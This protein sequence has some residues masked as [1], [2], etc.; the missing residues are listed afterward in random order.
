MKAS[1]YISN[2]LSKTDREFDAVTI[3]EINK[4]LAGIDVPDA[5]VESLSDIV[6]KKAAMVDRDIAE[7]HK[8][9]LYD[10]LTKSQTNALLAAGYTQDEVSVINNLD[11][12]DRL[13]KIIEINTNKL[14]TQYSASETEQ[15]ALA[16][17]E[18]LAEKER[19]EMYQNQLLKK[20]DDFTTYKTTLENET[21]LNYMID[22]I[23]FRTDGIPKDK[24]AELLKSELNSY[25]KSR[26]AKVVFQNNQA[27]VVDIND[28]TEDY[29]D[30]NNKL[31]DV[32][33]LTIRL[34]QSLNLVDKNVTE[35]KENGSKKIINVG[36]GKKSTTDVYKKTVEALMKRK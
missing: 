28:E 32:N 10:N 3:E 9:K 15:I 25:L 12:N 33:R 16:K 29:Y 22:K 8:N 5:I 1:E 2:I 27:R 34:A 13:N 11:I 23:R 6:S 21:K 24:A 19:A 31:L 20:Q 18:A 17:K 14:K 36:G 26:N 30:E 4:R 7:R 35:P